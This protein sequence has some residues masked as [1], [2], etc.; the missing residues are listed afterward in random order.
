MNVDAP[1]PGDT[2][3]A[4]SGPAS[5]G[6]YTALRA[7]VTIAG[8]C[9]FLQVYATQPL[10]PVIRKAFAASELQAAMTVGAASLAVALAAPLVGIMADAIGRKRVMVPA[11]LAM[12]IPTILGAT[13]H[14]LAQ[15]V[16]WRFMMGL[17]I[18][19]IIAVMLAY[20]AEEAADSAGAVMG[21]YVSGTVLGGLLGRF[22]AALVAA[23]FGWRAALV[24]LGVVSFMGGL[25][26]WRLLPRSRVFVPQRHAAEALRAMAG[27]LRNPRLLATYLVGFNALFTLLG[28]FSYINFHLAGQPFHLGTVALGS[29]FFVYALGVV[30]TPVAGIWIDRVGY[31]RA[32]LAAACIA[33]AGAWLTLTPVLWIVIAGLAVLS[34]GMFICQAAAS[35]H[36]GA[37]AGGSRSAAAGVYVC[38]YYLGGF[39]GATV[40]GVVWRYAAWPGCVATV[41]LMQLIAGAAAWRYFADRRQ[42]HEPAVATGD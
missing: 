10:L 31:R 4:Q 40:L 19:G 9:T 42:T 7:G 8:F 29:V 11:M 39:V 34:T 26:V 16:F 22:L 41:T 12:S 35:S 3:G 27:H 1:Y 21:S 6:G 13:S 37:A 25:A 32:L 14:T 36:V 17:C 24:V 28:T 33:I 15:L 2:P 23:R 5:C 18:P 30:V 20:I 38:F